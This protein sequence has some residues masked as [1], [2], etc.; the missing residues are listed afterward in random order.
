M[1]EYT[2]AKLVDQWDAKLT[3]ELS[4]AGTVAYVD[5]AKAALLPS[6]NN[7]RGYTLTLDDG[8]GTIEV[9][10]CTNANAING[11][12][13]LWRN[14]WDTTSQ[15]WPVG[16]TIELRVPAGLYNRHMLRMPIDINKVDA[17]TFLTLEWQEW[18]ATH[19]N[20]NANISVL[21]MATLV[22]FNAAL[23]GMI[24]HDVVIQQDAT[25]GRT[26]GWDA[27][28]RWPGGTAPTM[29]SAANALDLYRIFRV[30]PGQN[31]YFG[32]ILGQNIPM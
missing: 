30:S 29:S 23:A 16:S 7:G 15:I 18:A 1:P 4:L 28:I 14:R 21:S 10:H 13:T 22:Q 9:V 25:G 12:L 17:T 2:V 24:M 6:A 20:L 31:Y 11:A 5:P 19:I 26:V 3:A 32:V 8:N 27:L